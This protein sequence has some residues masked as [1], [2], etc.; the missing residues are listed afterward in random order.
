VLERAGRTVEETAP[1]S[2]KERGRTS[3]TALE[4]AVLKNPLDSLTGTIIAGFVLTVILYL[5]VKAMTP[6]GA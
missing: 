5:A 2:Q 4:D 6:V 3:G 1:A